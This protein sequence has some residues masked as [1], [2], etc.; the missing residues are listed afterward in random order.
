MRERVTCI[1]VM[2]PFGNT[3]R[4]FNRESSKTELASAQFRW[5]LTASA[6]AS[7][8]TRPGWKVQ[9]RGPG[10][11]APRR[12]RSRGPWA[13][14]AATQLVTLLQVPKSVHAAH[15]SI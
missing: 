4:N 5:G 1:L 8:V 3:E 14:Q 15:Q 10:P 11:G 12:F 7:A 9:A 6:P 2:V 13:P